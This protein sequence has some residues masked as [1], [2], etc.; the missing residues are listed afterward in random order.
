MDYFFVWTDGG[1]SSA[2]KLALKSNIRRVKRAF[3]CL[4]L[5]KAEVSKE[6]WRPLSEAHNSRIAYYLKG[7]EAFG[8]LLAVSQSALR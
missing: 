5:Q 8:F 1:C 3:F 2:I 4:V 7:Y 6:I